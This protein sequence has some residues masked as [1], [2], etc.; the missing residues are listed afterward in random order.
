M[1]KTVK[2]T[3]GDIGEE[4]AVKK[5]EKEGF[6]VLERNYLRK[7]GEIDIVAQK[8]NVLYFI[9]VKTRVTS[10]YINREEWCRPED[11]L[12]QRKLMRLKRAIQTYLL[13]NGRSLEE[14]WEFSAIIVILKRKT[15]EVYKIEH[16]ENLII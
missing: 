2:R 13:E 3:V 14:E 12:H 1:A 16:L 5:V 4:F 8:E 11:N 15:H 7:W 6:K 10:F 9:E